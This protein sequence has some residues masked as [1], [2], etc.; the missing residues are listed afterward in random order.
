VTIDIICLSSHQVV[1]PLEDVAL[2]Y[3]AIDTLPPGAGA[4]FATML[5][6]QS[7]REGFCLYAALDSANGPLIGFG[8]GFTGR[9]GQPWRDSL[10]AAMGDVA[11]EQWLNGY[12]E[13]AEF[14]VLPLWRRRGVGGRLHDC[15]LDHVPHRRAVLTVR[16][17]NRPARRFYE[18]RGWLALYHDFFA[19][20]GRGPYIVMGRELTGARGA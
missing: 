15:L 4:G 16:E 13:F 12:F 17:G 1:A 6:G 19:P 5:S 14:G 7:E 10:A 3:G 20:S 2:A 11:S 9:P 8:Y 18:R